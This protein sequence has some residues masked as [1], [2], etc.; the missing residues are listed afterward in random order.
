[1]LAVSTTG[2]AGAKPPDGRIPHP[3]SGRQTSRMNIEN[4]HVEALSD[5]IGASQVLAGSD[6]PHPEG[7]ASPWEFAAEIPR[8]SAEE[9]DLVMR[10]NFEH[11][12]S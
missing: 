12:V 8:L 4:R 11:L 2:I 10:G 1:M 9:Q 3:R 5:L 6:Y 7:L